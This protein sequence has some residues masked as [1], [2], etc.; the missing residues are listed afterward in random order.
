MEDLSNIYTEA[1][2]YLKRALRKYNNH[3]PELIEDAIQE[4]IIQVWRDMEAGVTPKLKILRRAGLAANKFINRNGEYFFGK[5]R[6]SREGITA[7][8][9]TTQKIKIFLDE[10]LPVHNWVYP[11]AIEVAKATGVSRTSVTAI[12]KNIREG[13]IDHMVYRTANDGSNRKDWDYY[14]TVSVNSLKNSDSTTDDWTDNPQVTKY[15]ASWEDNLLSDINLIEVIKKLHPDHQRVLYM[16]L[17]EGYTPTE[18]ARES[19]T[20]AHPNSVGRKYFQAALGQVHMLIDPYYG[21]CTKGHKRT[22]ETS[23]VKKRTDGYYFR[24]CLVC[25]KNGGGD[26]SRRARKKMGRPISPICPQG[27]TK[28]KIDSH[29]NLRCSKCRA[30]AQKR[31]TERKK[32]EQE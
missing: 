16:Y 9:T 31:Y 14:N 29:G 8:G 26:K 12:L 3:L 7:N 10:Y 20:V 17:Y 11:S 4:G 18:I 2:A 25:C 24:T 13:R 32:R 22:P 6:T 28:D 21:E 23:V 19:G 15:S 5:P 30:E 27:H 1:E